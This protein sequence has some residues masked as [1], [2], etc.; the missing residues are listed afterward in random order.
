MTINLQDIEDANVEI[1]KNYYGEEDKFITGCLHLL[2]ENVDPFAVALKISLIDNTN[3]THLFQHKRQINLVELAKKICDI[4]DFDRRVKQG[5]IELVN[6]LAKANG[7][8]NLFSFAT[9]Y[10]C[11]HNRNL[12]GKDDYSIFDN[13]LK[14]SLPFYNYYTDDQDIVKI[15]RYELEQWRKGFDYKAYH[16]YI[17]KILESLEKKFGALIGRRQFDRFIWWRN[18]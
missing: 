6:E 4:P 11:Y 2:P 13:V 17:G 1:S 9:K 10:C 5:D 15:T 3:S 7:N 12:Y 16:D 18:R 8:V 14:N